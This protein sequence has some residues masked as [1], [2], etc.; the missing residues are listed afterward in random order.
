MK[1]L[2]PEEKKQLDDLRKFEKSL[3]FLLQKHPNVKLYG[4]MSGDV[5]ATTT[6]GSGFSARFVS[7]DIF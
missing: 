7:T 1:D 5:K 2:K 6:I 4:T 3:R